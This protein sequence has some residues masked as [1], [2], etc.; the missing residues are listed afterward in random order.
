MEQWETVDAGWG[1]LAA[2]FA[3]F[4]EPSNVR[5]Y[6]S[7]HRAV[8]LEAG[9]SVLDLA[10]GAGL[11]LEL[12]SLRGADVAGID[13]SPRLVAIARDRNPDG[14]L[15]VGDMNHLP[16]PEA[17]FDVVT[18]FRGVWAT[19]PDALTEALRVLRPGGR[20][21]MTV[22]GHIKA[23]PGA[24]SLAPFALAAAPTVSNQAAMNQ[25]G[26]PGVGE[27]LLVE[28]GFADVERISIPFAWEFA[29][30][31][32]YARALAST[33]PAYEA[34]G[35]VG[36]EEFHRR[37]V[38][39]ASERVREGLPLRA[40]IDVAGFTARRRLDLPESYDDAFTGSFLSAYPPNETAEQMR[41]EDLDDDGYVSTVTKLWA[42]MP[43][44]FDQLFALQRSAAA[45]GGLSLRHRGVLTT[46]TAA[47]LGDS[48]CAYA[49]GGKLAGWAEDPQV[50]ASVLRG[51]DEALTA[52]ER[53]LARWARQV[54]G[55]PNSTTETDLEALRAAGFDDD[56][57]FAATLFVVL[58][59]AF[60]TFNDA[61]GLRLDR[62]VVEALPAVV[63]DAV[64]WGRESV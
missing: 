22:W 39:L 47:T 51:D 11:A 18:S 37:C 31:E 58:R 32:A 43:G 1:R 17:S 62:A 16:W 12:A 19:T 46:A 44:A 20:F 35:E 41:R 24:W 9:D 25:M 57:I 49:W 27:R 8:G 50:P 38:E 45:F 60:S 21:A 14:D 6:L 63:R 56:Q 13:A 5:E 55:D 33:G 48:A 26:R 15:R 23:S 2:D 53:V 10:C 54:V 28:A 4:S 40:E 59:L 29:D 30:P 7:L 36:A 64:T 42:R 34:I 52:Q 3:T 61:L